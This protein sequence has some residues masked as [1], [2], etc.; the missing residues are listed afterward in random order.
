MARAAE[1]I[2]GEQVAREER[3][4]P[5]EKP[6]RSFLGIYTKVVIV[7][8]FLPVFVMILFGFNDP[9]GRLNFTWQRFTLQWYQP[10]NLF[11]FE[12][13]NT[14]IRNSLVVAV[15]STLIATIL[16]ALIALALTRHRFKGRS[17]MNLF[18]FLPMAT[19][20]VAMGVSLLALFVT[21]NVPRDIKTIIIAHIMFSISY[22]VV[23]VKAR[24]S[25]FDQNLEHAAQDLGASPWVS[26]WTVTFPLI[27]P[28]ILAAGL[29]A[30]VLSIDDFVITSFNAGGDITIPL[31]IFGATRIGVPPQVNVIGTI[32][33]M[34]GVIYAL[35]SILRS[36]GGDTA[37][38]ARA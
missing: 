29:L 36:R 3:V 21:L 25:G 4:P 38:V 30:F 19:P 14:A 11:Q 33:F 8:L 1:P 6:E 20:E 31:W 28:G 13:L 15:F 22:V 18:L 17:G 5:P 2:A 35:A 16:G 34:I 12:D 23:T 24:T 37:R 32:I 9:G 26:F 7:Y 10:S 27:F